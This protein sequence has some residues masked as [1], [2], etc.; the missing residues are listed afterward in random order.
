MLSMTLNQIWQHDPCEES[1]DTLAATLGVRN[2]ISLQDCEDT[3]KLVDFNKPIPLTVVLKSNGIVDALWCVD[4]GTS[5]LIRVKVC[6]MSANYIAHHASSDLYLIFKH[7]RNEVDELWLETLSVP[8]VDPK[9]CADRLEQ[10]MDDYESKLHDAV[11]DFLAQPY[12]AHWEKVQRER[13]VMVIRLRRLKQDWSAMTTYLR[14]HL[15]VRQYLN[16]FLTEEE[17]N[18]MYENQL[19]KLLNQG[20]LS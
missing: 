16:D 8:V 9:A 4:R 19:V 14:T 5:R 15:Y 13:M 12:D 10:I 1:W 7:F 20:R 6:F 2:H 3:G 17:F 18:D 11:K